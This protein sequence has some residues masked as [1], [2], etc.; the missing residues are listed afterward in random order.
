MDGGRRQ[1]H[2]PPL[3]PV[4]VNLNN[5]NPSK[6]DPE[7]FCAGQAAGSVSQFGS[8]TDLRESAQ[9]ADHSRLSIILRK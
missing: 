7:A 9:W 3:L 8:V 6:P 5:G 4:F 1:A 2:A